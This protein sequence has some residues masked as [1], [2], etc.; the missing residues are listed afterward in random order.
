[1]ASVD[2]LNPARYATNNLPL[3][4]AKKLK[5]DYTELKQIIKGIAGKDLE[6]RKRWYSPTEEAYNFAR[7]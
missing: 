7:P 1:M 6:Q 5:I 2:L 4:Q 3:N